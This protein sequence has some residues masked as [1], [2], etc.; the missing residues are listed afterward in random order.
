MNK[1]IALL[2]DAENTNCN[3][4]DFI[5]E[6]AAEHGNLIIRRLYGDF[7]NPALSCWRDIG[8]RHGITVAQKFSY[9][10]GKNST[11]IELIMEAVELKVKEKIDGMV[12]VSGDSDY[13]G[14]LIKFREDNLQTIVIGGLYTSDVLKNCCNVFVLIPER[15][16]VET[17]TPNGSSEYLKI[18]APKLQG[19]KVVG[20]VDLP[21]ND[22]SIERLIAILMTIISQFKQSNGYALMSV[23][24]EQFQKS[25]PNI[26]IKKFGF[27]S[28]KKFFE[29]HPNH[30]ACELLL[31]KTTIFIKN[32]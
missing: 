26:K 2:I 18:Y 8:Q 19:T 7:T 22:K 30:F 13:A 16:S 5:L 1:R 4:I 20:K 27:S 28:W 9:R 32:K 10:K 14:L 29:K 6:K 31:D 21:G 3:E 24:I 17:V 11:D 15:K 25:Q 12:L 23:V